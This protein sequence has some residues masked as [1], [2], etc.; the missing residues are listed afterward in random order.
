MRLNDLEK[1]ALIQD[2]LN[3]ITWNS[4]CEK[5][6]TSLHTV[7]KILKKAN[8]TKDRI[9][10]SS[11]SLEKQELFK[12]MY[13]NNTTYNEM[14]ETLNCKGGTLTYWA[15]KLNL[16]MRG[17]GRN[18]M[19]PNKFLERTPESDY[20]L[21]YIFA[22][23]HIGVYLHEKGKN[24][25]TVELASEKNYVVNK[26]KEWY[27]NL[28]NIYERPYTLQD[29]TI[30]TMYK[31]IMNC[32]DLALWFKEVLEIDNIKHHTLNPHINI[33]WDI[34]RGFFD[35]DGCSSKREFILYSCSIV[36]LERIKEF[37]ESFGIKN[38]ILKPNYLDCY[39]LA[40]YNK[41]ELFK[42]VPLL[43]S[44][45]YYCHE[46]KFKNLEPYLSNEIVQT[47]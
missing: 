6:S 7:H 40:L 4:L 47:E 1:E 39:K 26:Y 9:E 24:H 3:G 22:D 25:Y 20:W 14:Y 2:Y 16:P 19:Y 5:Y 23:G 17:S 38:L 35:G 43:Y 44:N 46:Y 41:E 21:G 42:L 27:D 29:G 34:I 37:I 33:T 31:A 18:N 45:R 8:V 12:T 11:W 13:L 32:K 30:K 36:W 15:H 28:P 10:K